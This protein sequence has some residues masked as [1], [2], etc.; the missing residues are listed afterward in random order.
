V[1]AGAVGGVPEL[2]I[3][4]QLGEDGFQQID[5][6]Q[7]FPIADVQEA[8]RV[9]GSGARRA[10]GEGAF[11]VDTVVD[12]GGLPVTEQAFDLCGHIMAHG[13][14]AGRTM[15]VF[16][17]DGPYPAGMIEAPR[18]VFVGQQRG[19]VDAVVHGDH[20]RQMSGHETGG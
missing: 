20:Q 14:H 1:G 19:V 10:W 3:G 16:G 4:A 6:F 7:R 15:D 11:G 18:R 13:G 2:E 9:V 8:E 5:P 12:D 17:L